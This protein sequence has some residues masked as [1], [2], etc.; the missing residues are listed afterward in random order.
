MKKDYL[1]RSGKD[2]SNQ[3]GLDSNVDMGFSAK[4]SPFT[5]KYDIMR[6]DKVQKFANKPEK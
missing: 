6:L 1:M 4:T 3:G 2:F 5:V